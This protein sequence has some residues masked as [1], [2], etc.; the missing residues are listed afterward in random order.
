VLLERL[1]R[2]GGGGGEERVAP[3]PPTGDQNTGEGRLESP[4][5]NTSGRDGK[6]H[7]W[8]GK[9]NDLDPVRVNSRNQEGAKKK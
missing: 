7:C 9:K 3:R 4:G 1:Q 8:L 2:G 6:P 5:Q